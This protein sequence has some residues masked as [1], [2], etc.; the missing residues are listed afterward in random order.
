MGN[1][2]RVKHSHIWQNPNKKRKPTGK[3]Y[4]N[5]IKAYLRL[6]K[7]EKIEWETKWI[8]NAKLRIE[9]KFKKYG[10]TEEMIN[11]HK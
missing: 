10:I 11:S 1:G 9:T 4:I 6:I 5:A 7:R 8:K 3:K 2:I